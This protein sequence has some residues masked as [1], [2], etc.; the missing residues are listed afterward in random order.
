MKK[1]LE[2][3]GAARFV[4]KSNLLD[5]VTVAATSES[6]SFEFMRNINKKKGSQKRRRL[7]VLKFGVC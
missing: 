7:N 1:R 3:C 4:C 2:D 5:P 6:S